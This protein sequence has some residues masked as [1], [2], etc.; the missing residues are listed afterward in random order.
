MVEIIKAFSL[1]EAI[2]ILH[3]AQDFIGTRQMVELPNVENY[4][5][6]EDLGICFYKMVTAPGVNENQTV[7]QVEHVVFRDTKKFETMYVVTNIFNKKVIKEKFSKKGDAVAAARNY[8]EMNYEATNVLVGKS[9]TNTVR[10]QARISYK[11]S[12]K[13]VEGE[14]IFIK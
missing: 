5:K 9:L 10:D 8:T 7:T 11:P 2:L 1:D 6:Y 3:D 14:W 12:Q 4:E 13:Q